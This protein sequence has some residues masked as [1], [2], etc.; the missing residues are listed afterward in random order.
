MQRS[1][2][3]CMECCSVQ[4]MP[5]MLP[6]SGWCLLLQSPMVP[7]RRSSIRAVKRERSLSRMGSLGPISRRGSLAGDGLPRTPSRAL[8][9]RDSDGLAR[10][11][12]RRLRDEKP[13]ELTSSSRPPPGP[14][15][16]EEH[17]QEGLPE[18]SPR[19]EEGPQ[20]CTAGTGA[21]LSSQ[22]SEVELPQHSR[23]TAGSEGLYHS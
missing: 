12:S 6:K 2:A 8:S 17:G 15:I 13:T 4:R 18:V 3:A 9:L 11:P 1:C 10:T 7:R 23:S 22:A 20:E 14:T 16:R 5:T 19:H 21:N